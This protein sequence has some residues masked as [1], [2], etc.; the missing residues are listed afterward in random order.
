MFILQINELSEFDLGGD[1][2][3]V[4]DFRGLVGDNMDNSLLRDC[5]KSLNT[6]DGNNETIGILRELKL[7]LM[8]DKEVVITPVIL[9]P[10]SKDV[11]EWMKNRGT[12][13]QL[14]SKSQE[15]EVVGK[16]NDDTKDHGRR[17]SL[18]TEE[19]HSSESEN[20]PK[21]IGSGVQVSG[22]T[23]KVFLTPPLN[24]T[25]NLRE[26]SQPSSDVHDSQ[27]IPR[28]VL[29]GPQHSTPAGN[30]AEKSQK[31]LECTPIVGDDKKSLRQDWE[32]NDSEKSCKIKSLRRNILR[33][34]VKVSSLK[35]KYTFVTRL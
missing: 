12:S 20:S 10:S 34:Q 35:L 6:Y 25:L 26:S 21:T 33:N 13:N 18:D 2:K 27:N 7:A 4:R 5:L 23:T 29:N 1:F 11:T 19:Q 31:L 15:P 16:A 30:F 32:G 14:I 17:I 8:G 22:K 28:N 3:T 24:P 9:P